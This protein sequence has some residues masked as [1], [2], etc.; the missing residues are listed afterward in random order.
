MHVCVSGLRSTQCERQRYLLQTHFSVTMDTI[1]R[2]IS[3]SDKNGSEAERKPDS[4]AEREVEM[5]WGTV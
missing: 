1:S 3:M 4:K 2:E 5:R